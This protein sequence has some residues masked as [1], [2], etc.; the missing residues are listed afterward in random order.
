MMNGRA[1]TI[2]NEVGWRY[3]RR[4]DASLLDRRGSGIQLR[5]GLAVPLHGKLGEASRDRRV[6][7]GGQN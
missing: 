4:S 6:A 3:L 1:Q 2:H 7:K 5:L